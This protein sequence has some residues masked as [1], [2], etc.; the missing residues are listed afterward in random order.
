MKVE[1]IRRSIIKTLLDNDLIYN[2]D[3]IYENKKRYGCLILVKQ[4]YYE[5][6]IVVEPKIT[7]FEIRD[8]KRNQYLTTFINYN[9]NINKSYLVN[10]LESNILFVYD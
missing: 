10:N 5:L 6:K 4:K 3:F 8:I 1:D 9:T 7:Y 2:K